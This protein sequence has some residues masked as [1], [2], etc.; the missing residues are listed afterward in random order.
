MVKEIRAAIGSEATLRLD[1]N[2][3]WSLTEAREMMRR[4]E[5]L[6]VRSIEEPTTSVLA[7]ARL[8]ET[9]SIGFS[10]HDANIAQAVAL[11]VPDAFVINLTAL[12]GIRRSLRFIAACEQLGIDVWFYS[13]DTGIAQAAYLQVVAAVPW[14]SQPSQT[15]I[16]WHV[17]DVVAGGP[18]RPRDGCIPIPDGPGFGVTLDPEALAR[19][20]RRFREDGPYDPYGTM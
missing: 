7:L 12:G 18:R 11:G 14:L 8:R 5:A 20:H 15:L 17:D 4:L 10:T 1:A 19:C 16:R 13:P 6:D 3:A 9:T 2:Q